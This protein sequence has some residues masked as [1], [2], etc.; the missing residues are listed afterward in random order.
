MSQLKE[1]K[2]NDIDLKERIIQLENELKEE[3]IKNK[4]LNLELKELK[5]ELENEK[6]K[7]KE[8]NTKSKLINLN[9]LLFNEILE[10]DREIKDLKLKL[11][12]FPFE[13]KEGERLLSIIF[14][15]VEIF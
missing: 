10:R 7:N 11:S 1:E 12:R 8:F 5:Q 6:L 4:N 13:L 15:S 14:N 3:K 2:L 9:E